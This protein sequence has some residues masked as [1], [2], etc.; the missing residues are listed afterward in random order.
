[1]LSQD[2]PGGWLHSRMAGLGQSH[3]S[4][5]TAVQASSAKRWF[6][7]SLDD[8]FKLRRGFCSTRRT[9]GSLFASLFAEGLPAQ[10]ACSS[11]S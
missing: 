5:G 7:A 9:V 3:S 1:L 2:F 10:G 4:D 6:D 8:T 11:G